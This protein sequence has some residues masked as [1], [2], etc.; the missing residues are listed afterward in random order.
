MAGAQAG[1]IRVRMVTGDDVTTGAA[2]A[3]QLGQLGI[4]GEAVLGADFAAWSEGLGTSEID[5][6][7]FGWAVL[8]A[9]ALL[10][11]WGKF[12]ARRSGAA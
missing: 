8:A 9:L 10:L 11:L 12:L 6:R 3:R 2:I 7:Q 5:A 4:P 1:H